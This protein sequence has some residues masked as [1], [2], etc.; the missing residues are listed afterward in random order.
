MDALD[1]FKVGHFHISGDVRVGEQRCDVINVGVRHGFF[2]C[3][4]HLVLDLLAMS[5]E[6]TSM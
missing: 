4:Q 6:T 5:A 2:P 3:F 1:G